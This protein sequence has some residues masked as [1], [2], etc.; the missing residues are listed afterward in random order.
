MVVRL[1]V[2]KGGG[3]KRNPKNV[4]LKKENIIVK[5]KWLKKKKADKTKT[6]VIT[7]IRLDGFKYMPL[8]NVQ[9]RE[10]SARPESDR[11]GALPAKNSQCLEHESRTRSL[12]K[13]P[14]VAESNLIAVCCILSRHSQSSFPCS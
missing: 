1:Q 5:K 2:Y 7:V 12:L 3:G 14:A 10:D 13:G 9:C 11:V 8:E 4:G 6:Q